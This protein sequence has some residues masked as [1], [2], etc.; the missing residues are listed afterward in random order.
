MLHNLRR[1][2]QGLAGEVLA[3]DP[4]DL[5]ALPVGDDA[6][7]D[8]GIQGRR[9]GGLKR[10][11]VEEQE[12]EWQDLQQY[13]LQQEELIGEVGERGAEDGE[14]M[15]VDGEGEGEGDGVNA[16]ERGL[17]KRDK[18]AR[19]DEKKKRRK[20]ERREKEESKTKG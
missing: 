20:A 3:A 9:K 7:L 16:G 15:D 8:E 13:Q 1:I 10:K 4:D 18:E 17:S 5:F 19:K 11:V 2:Q 14:V 12:G 6:K